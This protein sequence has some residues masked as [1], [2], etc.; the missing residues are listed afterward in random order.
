MAKFFM[1]IFL[2]FIA[3]SP[4]SSVQ[5]QDLN[6]SYYELARPPETDPRVEKYMQEAK[7]QMDK[8]NYKEANVTFRKILA[9]NEVLPVNMGYLFAETLYMIGQYE[10]SSNFLE[11][12]MR[13][14]GHGGDYYKQAEELNNLLAAKMEVIRNCSFCNHE[15]YRLA[16]CPACKQTG[17]IK[18][19][20]HYCKGRGIA[21]CT[22]CTGKGVVISKNVLGDNEYHSCTNCG[23]KG[24]VQCPVCKG[25]RTT[26]VFC[27]RCGGDGL[28]PTDVICD[29]KAV[30]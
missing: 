23:T 6:E 13:L 15:G 29:H 2:L 28:Q 18:Q 11:K 21:T 3:S 10:N 19:E 26:E 27:S 7:A 4:L 16:P 30:P 20:C 25:A 5:G 22:V 12:Y 1:Y 8:G 14:S 24:Y 9:L 17:K